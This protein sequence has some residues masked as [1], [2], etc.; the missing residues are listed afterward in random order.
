MKT[1]GAALIA[2][3]NSQQFLVADLYTFTLADGTALYFTSADGSLV[4]G[5]NTFVASGP[6]MTRGTTKIQVGIEVDTLDITILTNVSTLY[7]SVP[8]AQFA[9]QGGFDGA[10]LKLERVFMGTWG[11]TSAGTLIMFVGRVAETTCTRAEVVLTIN[12][13]LELLNI[14]VP[15]NVYQA[16]CIHSLYDSGCGAVAATF[17]STGNTTANSTAASVNCNL[18]Q[19]NGYF[20]LGTV[21]YTSGVNAGVSRSVKTYTSGVVITS[22]AFPAAP[23]LG[24]LFTIKPGCDKLATTC[25]NTFSNFANFR[26]YPTIPVAETVY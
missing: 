1:A 5:G 18:A 24:D 17:T 3:L 21:R 7:G 9:Q 13:D 4:Y 6:L 2:L 22:L 12:S 8:A 26:G 19:A 20:N 11:D 15:K 10:R 16:G 23:A 14:P 25:T